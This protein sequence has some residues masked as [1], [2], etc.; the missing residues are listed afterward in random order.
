[1][2]HHSLG[3]LLTRDRKFQE[4]LTETPW[5]SQKDSDGVVKSGSLILEE[6]SGSDLDPLEERP[7]TVESQ[8]IDMS[9]S[10][11]EMIKTPGNTLSLPSSGYHSLCSIPLD[12]ATFWEQTLQSNQLQELQPVD[13]LGSDDMENCWSESSTSRKGNFNAPEAIVDGKILENNSKTPAAHT[14]EEHPIQSAG[15][16]KWE[17]PTNQIE[18]HTLGYLLQGDE[19]AIGEVPWLMQVGSNPIKSDSFIPK[20]LSTSDP[21]GLT[22]G[23]RRIEGSTVV[24]LGSGSANLS[25]GHDLSHYIPDHSIDH[26]YDDFDQ[27]DAYSEGTDSGGLSTVESGNS[28][29]GKACAITDEVCISIASAR[30]L[31]MNIEFSSIYGEEWQPNTSVILPTSSSNSAVNW[32]DLMPSEYITS[33]EMNSPIVYMDPSTVIVTPHISTEKQALLAYS[34]IV[35]ER[36]RVSGF[37]TSSTAESA[38]LL[39]REDSISTV[40][41]S[42]SE[43]SC[44]PHIWEAYAAEGVYAGTPEA[45]RCLQQLSRNGTGISG[46]EKNFCTGASCTRGCVI[47]QTSEQELTHAKCGI[48]RPNTSVVAS[49]QARTQQCIPRSGLS[50]CHS[51]PAQVRLVSSKEKMVSAALSPS[52]L[53]IHDVYAS[54]ILGERN[55]CSALSNSN[56]VSSTSTSHFEELSSPANMQLSSSS[57][58]ARW[59]NIFLFPSDFSGLPIAQKNL[60]QDRRRLSSTSNLVQ[61]SSSSLLD[62]TDNFSTT[63]VASCSWVKLL[64]DNSFESLSSTKQQSKE[65]RFSSYLLDST[66]SFNSLP[67]MPIC[68]ELLEDMPDT[69]SSMVIEREP[70]AVPAAIVEEAHVLRPFTNSPY[71]HF[72]ETMKAPTKDSTNTQNSATVFKETPSAQTSIASI[73]LPALNAQPFPESSTMFEMTEQHSDILVRGTNSKQSSEEMLPSTFESKKCTPVFVTY[74]APVFVT[75]SASVIVSS[76]TYFCDTHYS[77]QRNAIAPL[78]VR[79][80]AQSS[81]A[82][83]ISQLRLNVNDSPATT[84]TE[85]AHSPLITVFPTS[86]DY[87]EVCGGIFPRLSSLEEKVANK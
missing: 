86:S 19:Q 72:E 10:A 5:L 31:D 53:A 21:A 51:N 85:R 17:E 16:T 18:H 38:A 23:C 48:I 41:D 33:Q 4:A 45:E 13:W 59:A 12:L 28:V 15:F 56:A 54:P 69:E 84:P 57:T 68:M 1:M 27:F 26:E 7:Q 25:H 36:E 46:S 32:V 42:S 24:S 66:A 71:M 61:G 87:F 3:Y 62:E 73:M 6:L 77:V 82:P 44:L 55:F 83:S 8:L 81:S 30:K 70:S 22:E 37:K 65:A 63:A 9:H 34:P 29:H 50:I 35:L 20:N 60:Q 11:P 64:E 78:S 39:Q 2:G 74:S 49:F 47:A 52:L 79:Q 58:I 75:Y 14:L 80:L 40:F 67:P 76:P 43:E